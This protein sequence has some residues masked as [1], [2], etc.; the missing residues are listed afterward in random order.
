[1]C[2]PTGEEI[3]IKN[4]RLYVNGIPTGE[5]VCQC[6]GDT[7]STLRNVADDFHICSECETDWDEVYAPDG[8][9]HFVYIKDKNGEVE[10]VKGFSEEQDAYEYFEELIECHDTN[11]SEYT[12]DDIDD[13]FEQGTQHIGSYTLNVESL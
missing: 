13:M 5:Y 3:Q 9:N 11:A 6:C 1:M 12:R 8:V 2:K 10:A 4:T 7:V